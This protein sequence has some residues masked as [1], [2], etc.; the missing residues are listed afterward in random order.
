M[1]SA[2][3]AIIVIVSILLL[4]VLLYF[5]SPGKIIGNLPFL[6]RFY[7]NTT[8][9]IITQRGKAKVWINQKEY[10][11]TPL[12]IEDLP[13]G[14]YQI[15]LQKITT[16]DAF[17]EKHTF[18]IELS[19]NTSARIDIEIGPNKLLHG[20]ILYYTQARTSSKTGYITITGNTGESKIYID[21]EFRKNSPL[22]NL[23]LNDG[24][25]QVKVESEGYETIEIPIFV[26]QGY[27]LNLKTYQFPIPISLDL[28]NNKKN[29]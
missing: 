11:E 8:I 17:Y 23:E 18:N 16:E 6:N 3:T 9:E 13:E 14:N 22:T 20:T 5:F 15:E 1:K 12:T 26:R 19:K 28:V 24:Q 10:G 7:N 29:E 21:S 2:K 4:S 27:Q 25:Y